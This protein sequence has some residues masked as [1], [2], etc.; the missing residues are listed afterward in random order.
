MRYASRR[1]RRQGKH[2]VP[3]AAPAPHRACVYPRAAPAAATLTAAIPH[4]AAASPRPASPAPAAR[5]VPRGPRP[6]AARA[7]RARPAQRG[8]QGTPAPT[9]R[10]ARATQPR[11]GPRLVGPRVVGG[12]RGAPRALPP[13]PPRTAPSAANTSFPGR[14][15]RPAVGGAR[16]G[17]AHRRSAAAPPR[18]HERK[19]KRAQRSDVVQRAGASAPRAAGRFKVRR[20]AQARR[21]VL[22]PA[23][24]QHHAIT[25]ARLRPKAHGD[26]GA[27]PAHAT[28]ARIAP[29]A[30][31]ED[32][33]DVAAAR[34]RYQHGPVD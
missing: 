15:A 11:R 18:N 23:R 10:A 26:G 13:P 20:Q 25:G 24:A 22:L 2:G 12:P 19:G 30:P 4:P 6:R 17:R 32:E 27:P 3:H 28:V 8:A 21:V 5:A 1:K 34:G 31:G 33:R 29:V 9:P 16:G 7:H 14:P